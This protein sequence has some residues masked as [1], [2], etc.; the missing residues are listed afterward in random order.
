MNFQDEGSGQSESDQ[1]ASA[2]SQ[3]GQQQSAPQFNEKTIEAARPEPSEETP[4]KLA[5]S[6]EQP[7]RF[8]K[9]KLP[10]LHL[11]SPRISKQ[12]FKKYG[13]LIAL[14]IIVLAG[15]GIVQQ[16]HASDTNKWKKI[17][18]YHSR[19]EYQKAADLLKD[20]EP[21]KDQKRLAVYA[22]TMLATRQLDRALVG[23]QDLYKA[24][25]DVATKL[26]IGNI[27]NEQKNYKDAETVY[28]EVISS[29][30]S[31]VQ[32]YVNL[33]TLYKLQGKSKEA[34][35]LAKKA[36]AANPGSVVL[37]E[38]QVSML[39]EDKTNPDYKEAV[40]AL[41]KLNPQDPLLEAIKQN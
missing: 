33:A 39:L 34:A 22:Q 37:Q 16:K 8:K 4:S 9:P 25:K 36:V 18:D 15:V 7:P 31:N 12:F 19:A 20:T 23:Y 10:K 6:A 13:V 17:T 28:L 2:P 26:I 30:S 29:N 5:Q 40:A 1:P 3:Q 41:R 24:N 14:A 38:L 35:Q 32:A 11:K 21:P 27:Y